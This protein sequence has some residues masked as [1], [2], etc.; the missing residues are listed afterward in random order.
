MVGL[1]AWVAGVCEFKNFWLI[2]KAHSS[3]SKEEE[4]EEKRISTHCHA[5][6]SC[7]MNSRVQNTFL[8]QVLD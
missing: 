2:R 5:Y 7:L 4:E 8:R 3:T 6:T 1:C